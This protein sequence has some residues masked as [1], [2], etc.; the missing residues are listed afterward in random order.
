MR[1]YFVGDEP[2]GDPNITKVLPS[3]EEVALLSWQH[4]EVVEIHRRRYMLKDD[5]LEIFLI[6]GKT[7]L[8][9]F[10]STAVCSLAKTYHFV[11]WNQFIRAT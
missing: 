7:M 4:S 1:C 2:L 8:L 5:A 10:E 9:S 6:S 11:A 3:D